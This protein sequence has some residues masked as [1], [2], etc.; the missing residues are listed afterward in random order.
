MFSFFS[1]SKTNRN[2]P[3]WANEYLSLDFKKDQKALAGEVTYV[4]LDCETTGLSKSDHIVTIGAVKCTS[5]EI[6]VDQ[7]LDQKYSKNSFGKSSEI[8]GE[9]GQIEKCDTDKLHKE[10]INF[11][12]NHIVVGHNITFDIGMISRSLKQSHG[13]QL[14]NMILDTFSLAT[15]VDPVKYERNIGG[16]DLLQLDTLCLEN[17]IEIQNRHTALGDAYM[18]AQL[19]QKLLT[20]LRK[21][22][23]HKVSELRN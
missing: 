7:L 11:L 10:L 2:L 1:R 9:L 3:S 12:W 8:H 4:V 23:I 14:R 16:K 21:R 17:H 6:F 5:R 20:K 13:F 18:T 15:R 19:L 22:G